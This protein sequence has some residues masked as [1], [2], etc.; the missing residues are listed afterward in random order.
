MFFLY[1]ITRLQNICLF[2]LLMLN[3]CHNYSSH[4]KNLIVR[5]LHWWLSALKHFHSSTYIL[6]RYFLPY[7]ST[8]STF[9]TAV[10]LQ[11]LS[12]GTSCLWK[13]ALIH[14]FYVFSLSRLHLPS[15]FFS[16]VVSFSNKRDST[17]FQI[18]W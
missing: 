1:P 8:E 13:F 12:Y 17:S 16:P 15:P 4:L 3:I 7:L 11:H 18:F 10:T 2:K 9:K 6:E 14:S 5:M